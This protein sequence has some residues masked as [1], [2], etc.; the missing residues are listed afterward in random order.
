MSAELIVNVAP[1]QT[2]VALLESGTV[3]EVH[4]EDDGARGVTSNIYKGR[5]KRVLP[6]MQ[7]AFVEIGLER[8]AF[9]YV[10]DVG[11]DAQTLDPGR[12]SLQAAGGRA[13]RGEPAGDADPSDPAPP[14]PPRIP[15]ERQLRAGQEVVVQVAKGPIGTKGARVTTRLTLPGRMLVLMPHSDHVGVSRRI[16]DS[17]ERERLRELVEELRPPGV[18]FIVRTAAE[19][20]APEALRSDIEVLIALWNDLV[21]KK[22]KASAPSM[23]FSDLDLSLRCIRDLLTEQLDRVVVDD[24]QE[25]D[26]ICEFAANVMPSLA[27]R[28]ELYDGQEPIFDA[29]DVEGELARAVSPKVWLRSGGYI[30]IEQTE[31]LTTVD[32]NTGRYVGR[33]NLE[34]TLL[35]TN[36]EAL[37]EIA[38]Q[39]RL[40]DLGGIIVVDF[41]DMEKPEHRDKVVSSLTDAL[42]RDRAR[43]VVHP[44]SALGLVE[45]TRKRVRKSLLRRVT[46]ACE[47]CEGRGYVKSVQAIAHEVI[48]EVQRVGRTVRTDSLGVHVHPDVADFLCGEGRHL[49]E[50][51]EEALDKHTVTLPVAGWS[52]AEYDVIGIDT[53]IGP[54]RRARL[55]AVED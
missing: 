40:R 18:G 9:L 8:A 50:A 12:P 3:A 47:H 36:L 49:V 31:A 55:V 13:D 11:A 51:L 19:G 25:Y 53:G 4:H 42:R 39:L 43:T 38:Y 30:V 7:A 17:E 14:R 24:A 28:V 41:I 2:R 33:R 1:G 54:Q 32:V 20:A 48:R 34:E 35:K 23:L 26:R 16:P 37:K 5:V 44:M 29:F 22:G 45:L 52:H 6:G 15:I 10:D 27:H 21:R 46:D